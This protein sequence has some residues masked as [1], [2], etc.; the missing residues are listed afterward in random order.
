MA[1]EIDIRP[2]SGV[3]ATYE[4]LSYQPWTALA[5]F[6]DN[7]TQ[8]FFDH[9]EELLHECGQKSLCVLIEHSVDDK[10]L[11]ITDD[12]Y[13]MEFE[14][15]QRAIML[16]RPPL[17]T[18]GRNEYG[19]GLKTA[20]CWFGKKWTVAT[21]Q[22]GSD[23][24]YS[25][26]MDINKLARDKDSTVKAEVF[27]ADPRD[28]YTIITI[29]NL[30][31]KIIG[32]TCGKV[33][34]FLSSIYRQDIRNGDL[35]IVYK[36][37]ELAFIDP[38]VYEEERQDGT[39]E[40]WRK[41]IRFNV[42]YEGKLLPV[43]GF[44]GIRKKGSLKDAGFTLLRR[45]RVIVGGPE[46]NYRPQELFG[47]ANSFAYQRL[48]GELHMDEWPVTQAKD[49]FD[50]HNSGLEES[51]IEELGKLSSEYR[52]KADTVR[53]NKQSTDIIEGA[54]QNLESAG[55]I[56]N[57]STE[58]H[59]TNGKIEESDEIR[60]GD[61]TGA[62]EDDPE[63]CVPPETEVV[64]SGYKSHDVRFCYNNQEYTFTIE[65]DN[66]NP[67][68]N[69]LLVSRIANDEHA[70][71]IKLDMKHPFFEPFIRN[72]EFQQ[73][74]VKLS[75]AIVLAECDARAVSPN[76]DGLIRAEDFRW[77]MNKILADLA[78]KKI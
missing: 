5:E 38:E 36:D 6:V 21:T 63:M 41:E 74:M 45:G 60:D 64:V 29:E 24:G 76:Q 78:S 9:R 10:S 55:V 4:R 49:Q 71:R 25:V 75:I 12:A 11:I 2:T 73:T 72:E 50:W 57:A 67:Q 56:H 44:I 47:Y 18:L 19:M 22:Y 1:K 58:P 34:D 20:A 16:D 59:A 30:K 42:S 13:G 33:K 70:Y 32:R 23:K 14:D 65:I 43:C 7:S 15:F 62:V 68:H 3:Y 46:R 77:R 53:K 54:V 37:T 52:K 26:T 39:K 27:A 31:K 48:F 35:R 17:N 51:F 40:V 28:H 69:W 66:S 61:A 8:S